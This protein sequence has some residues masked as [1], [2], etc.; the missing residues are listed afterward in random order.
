MTSSFIWLPPSLG[1]A[2]QGLNVSSYG[3]EPYKRFSPFSFS[4]SYQIPVPGQENLIAHSV[5]GIW[6]G[7]KVIKG[8]PDPTLFTKKPRKRKGEVEGHLFGP[9]L[10]D[11]A[12]ARKKIYLPAYLYH[13]LNHILDDVKD[14]LEA[15][16]NSGP[17]FLYDVESNPNID[18]LSQPYAHSSLLV[19][20]LNLLI[21][22]PLPPFNKK[23]FTYL[24]DQLQATLQ[25]YDRLKPQEKDLF[26]EIISFA[27]LFSPDD[28]KATFA[29]RALKTGKLGSSEHL[30]HYSP[31][32]LTREV[33]Q[34]LC[35]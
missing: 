28:L 12:Q 15:R 32:P 2:R 34:E 9:H 20:L 16:L 14:D 8:Q 19:D 6:Q 23:R 7:L 21:A 4:L 35:R 17:V 10:L 31:S 33:Y 18:D 1:Q 27:Y 25:F 5:E 30:V 3:P 24:E 26:K 11:Y 29:L 22:S 13:A